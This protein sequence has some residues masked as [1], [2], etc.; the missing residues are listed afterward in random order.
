MRIALFA[1]LA[2]IGFDGILTSRVSS[3]EERAEDSSRAMRQ[4]IDG[5]V[6][7]HVGGA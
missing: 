6:R 3:W 5:L 1:G 4:A 7:R 2:E